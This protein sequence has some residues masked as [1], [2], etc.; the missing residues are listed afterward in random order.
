MMLEGITKQKRTNTSLLLRS[1]IESYLNFM[2]KAFLH[3]G[4]RDVMAKLQKMEDRLVRLNLKGL[5]ATG[6]ILYLVMAAWKMGHNQE[7]LTAETYEALM[8]KSEAV[9][10][11]WLQNFPSRPEKKA[12]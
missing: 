9:T 3:P 1:V 6:Q 5:R 4:E 8:D 12:S 10:S 2:D 7:P 11:Q